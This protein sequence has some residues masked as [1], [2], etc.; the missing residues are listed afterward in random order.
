ML[1][2]NKFCKK[3]GKRIT[4]AFSLRQQYCVNCYN[5]NGNNLLKDGYN[6]EMLI[7]EIPEKIVKKEIKK[8]VKKN[9]KKDL[10]LK[11]IKENVSNS[12]I[13]EQTNVSKTYLAKL[14][15]QL[16]K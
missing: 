10:V 4:Y 5:E 14:Q 7:K 9:T 6:K 8:K 1:N 12:E 11:L 13:I 2:K 16:K 15:K 3:C